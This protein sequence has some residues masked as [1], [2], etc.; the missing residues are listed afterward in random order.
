MEER[1]EDAYPQLSTSPVDEIL[2][3]AA[4][5]GHGWPAMLGLKKKRGKCWQTFWW[6]LRAPPLV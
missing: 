3:E 5:K 6:G 2:E 4:L 1:E